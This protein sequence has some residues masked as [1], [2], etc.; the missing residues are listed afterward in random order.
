VD[1]PDVVALSDRTVTG[2]QIIPS[3]EYAIVYP[4]L[5]FMLSSP[6]TFVRVVTDPPFHPPIKNRPPTASQM[7]RV[8]SLLF[9]NIAVDAALAC[10]GIDNHTVP[11]AS[12]E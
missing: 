4:V 11:V 2:V 3:D 9:L 10:E 1:A 8:T 7:T 6:N 12:V 5:L